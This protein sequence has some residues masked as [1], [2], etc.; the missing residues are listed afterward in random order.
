LVKAE[1]TGLVEAFEM[2]SYDKSSTDDWNDIFY[3]IKTASAVFAKPYSKVT[4]YFNTVESILVPEKLLTASS[5]E[6]YLNLVHGEQ[7]HLEVKYDKLLSTKVFI[8]AY[9]IRRSLSELLTRQFIIYQSAHSYSA[10]LN[11]VL[12]RPRLAPVFIKLQFYSK[13]FIV[14]FWKGER[15]QMVQ[16]FDFKGTEDVLYYLLRTLQQLGLNATEAQVEL[17]GMIDSHTKTY[18]QLAKLFPHLETDKAPPNGVFEQALAENE[19]HY[20]TPF[21]KLLA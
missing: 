14:A 18:E 20:L 4:A 17:S 21:F 11:D 19:A 13:H 6:D 7:A 2:F 5:A 12:R 15:L 3:E 9:R 16:S 8:N 10:L 1:A